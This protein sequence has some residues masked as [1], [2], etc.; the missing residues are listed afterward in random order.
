MDTKLLDINQ[1]MASIPSQAY[2][3]EDRRGRLLIASI[4][5]FVFSSLFFAGRMASR[6]MKT[7]FQKFSF[8]ASDYTLLA[9]LILA[10]AIF[11]MYI[12]GKSFARKL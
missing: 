10:W 7:S 8:D 2:L 1:S 5:G 3:N 9:G 4:L 12:R 6:L 11:A